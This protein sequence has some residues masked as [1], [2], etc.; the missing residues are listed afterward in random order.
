M[1]DLKKKTTAAP[2]EMSAEEVMQKFDKESNKREPDGFWGYV[3]SAICIL[4]ACFQL[5]TG[6]F[7]V[8]DAHLQR[9]IHLCFGMALIYLLYPARAS[10]SRKS[11][12]PVDLVFAVLSVFAT[13][14]IFFQYD[15][16]VLRAGMNTET[17]IMVG[18][19]GIVLVFRIAVWALTNW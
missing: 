8:L 6:I 2:A 17:D 7:G 19:L 10:W 3:I 18:I 16:L 14:Y 11:M 4:F 13:M 9:T 1:D 12:H 15:E 5:Y